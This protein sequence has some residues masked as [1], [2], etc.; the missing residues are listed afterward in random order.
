[1]KTYEGLCYGEELGGD[2]VRQGGG[3]T[4]AA[5]VAGPAPRY[6]KPGGVW[7]TEVVAHRMS[8]GVQ[9]LH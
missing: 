5:I 2:G 8:L 3:I 9:S 4:H 1:M 6:P 7:A